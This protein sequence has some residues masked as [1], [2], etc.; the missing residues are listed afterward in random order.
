MRSLFLQSDS[1]K[2]SV[3]V[4]LKL[5]FGF[6]E[7]NWVLELHRIVLSASASGN[8]LINSSS[9]WLNSTSLTEIYSEEMILLS[10]GTVSDKDLHF[11]RPV[12]IFS[13]S[14][15]EPASEELFWSATDAKE[16]WISSSPCSQPLMTLSLPERF[17]LCRLRVSFWPP[18]SGSWRERFKGRGAQKNK[19]EKLASENH[20][21]SSGNKRT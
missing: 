18:P 9:P 8:T 1:L 3:G 6:G 11:T 10:D 4:S 2:S 16:W 21:Q 20:D 5:N 19:S 7:G 17:W 12:V 14:G 15:V 13:R